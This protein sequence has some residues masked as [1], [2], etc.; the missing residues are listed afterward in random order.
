MR[1]MQ[2]GSVF[3]YP[4]LRR[5]EGEA[6]AWCSDSTRG[7]L[8]GDCAPRLVG[9]SGCLLDN[10]ARYRGHFAD[11][12]FPLLHISIPKPPA[13]YVFSIGRATH[14][15]LQPQAHAPDD[16]ST[17]SHSS[18]PHLSPTPARQPT[19]ASAP[20]P[21]SQSPPPP[22]PHPPAYP[23]VPSTGLRPRVSGRARGWIGLVRAGG[24][25]SGRRR[26]GCVSCRADGGRTCY[27]GRT[28]RFRSRGGW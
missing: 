2:S 28:Q 4:V 19:S 6:G 21:A 16:S 22:H 25:V 17:P 11:A 27:A 10:P 26:R 23:A 1:G 7:I 8:V 12:Q 20:P 13:T 15:V 9:A 14:Q 18:P 5:K 3:C 24:R